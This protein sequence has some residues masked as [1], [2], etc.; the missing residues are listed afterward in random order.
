VYDLSE[1]TFIDSSGIRTLV[2]GCPDQS[3]ALVPPG[4]IIERV[5]EIVEI[6]RAIP[7]CESREEA[8]EVLKNSAP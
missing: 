3:A 8:L 5:L 6:E 7:V 4:H 1:L 2:Q